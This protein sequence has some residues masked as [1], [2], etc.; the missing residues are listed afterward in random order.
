MFASAA[1][2]IA[3]LFESLFGAKSGR[4]AGADVT[5]RE[6]AER[7]GATARERAESWLA[8]PA[9]YADNVL[10]V[11]HAA[12]AGRDQPPGGK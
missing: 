7:L 11:V 5:K 9:E 8:T 2:I 3:Q 6:L 4:V 1:L 10:T 12:L